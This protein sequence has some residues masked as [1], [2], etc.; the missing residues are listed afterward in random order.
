[1]RQKAIYAA[2][3]LLVL[4]IFSPLY[5]SAR[6]PSILC[7]ACHEMRGPFLS[8]RTS[9]HRKYICTNCHNAPNAYRMIFSHITRPSASW[10]KIDK[11]SFKTCVQ[12][13]RK[14]PDMVYFHSIKFPHNSH[15]KYLN[16][17]RVCHTNVVHGSRIEYRNPPKK[18]T[19]FKCHD[20]KTAS[21][22]CGLCHLKFTKELPQQLDPNWI[23]SHKSDVTKFRNA[24][25]NCHKKKFCTDC[26]M[27]V[28]PHAKTWMKAHGKEARISTRK[29]ENC[30]TSRD[31]TRCHA[32]LQ[33]HRTDWYD[34]H[35]KYARI[36]KA[37]CVQCHD[38][39]FCNSCHKGITSHPDKWLVLHRT[40]PEAKSGAA[41][42]TCHTDK[43]CKDCHV[44]KYTLHH[45]G[46]WL[47]RHG[48]ALSAGGKNADIEA[49]ISC[50]APNFCLACHRGV[51]KNVHASNFMTMH[52]NVNAQSIPQCKKCHTLDYCNNCH[53]AKLP[54]DHQQP[55]WKS[56]HGI[57]AIKNMD[58]CTLCHEKKFCEACHSSNLPAS[59]EAKDW[60]TKHGAG[61]REKGSRCS[62][63]HDDRFCNICHKR[64]KPLDHYMDNWPQVH[65]RTA[66]FDMNK[67]SICHDN[68][69][70]EK[71]HKPD[72]EHQAAGWMKNHD[73]SRAGKSFTACEKCHWLGTCVDC[74]KRYG[75]KG[76]ADCTACHVSM[77]NHKNLKKK[78]CVQ[79]HQSLPAT[80]VHKK[81]ESLV[82]C[83]TCHIPHSM[84]PDA[85]VCASCHDKEKGKDHTMGSTCF[86]CHSFK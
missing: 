80:D 25:T 20:N 14:I 10:G 76:H 4:F 83:D 57:S 3:G 66:M 45:K 46:N 85:A 51:R 60:K 28:N 11:T 74:H 30:H 8:W 56:G 12:C 47:S 24:C 6:R 13:H 62:L 49:C 2:I 58:S 5:I 64:S 79:C 17:C 68:R 35:R 53:K 84:K 71:C 22:K 38:N 15:R 61:S 32:I 42:K 26:H 44:G 39:A 75:I 50:H 7:A 72:Q 86:D 54:A 52:E 29:C 82:D 34:G 43:Y 67:C 41:C 63:C 31:C 77:T 78:P 81:H 70:C 21:R 69:D 65:G 33:M 40:A 37:R 48:A 19:C 9:T 16:D 73:V 55:T 36:S 18:K 23:R 27:K 59:H 1:M